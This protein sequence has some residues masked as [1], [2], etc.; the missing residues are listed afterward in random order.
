MHLFSRGDRVARP[1][2]RNIVPAPDI[3]TEELSARRRDCD[4]PPAE[5]HAG[6]VD[7]KPVRAMS[8]A[9]RCNYPPRQMGASRHKDIPLHR[10]V[11]LEPRGERRARHI[12]RGN[13]MQASNNKD[14]SG[15][16][17]RGVALI[18]ASQRQERNREQGQAL[19]CLRASSDV[20]SLPIGP[21]SYVSRGSDSE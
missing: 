3:I 17:R 14:R 4:V 21:L 2:D 20:G 18:R 16:N 11:M 1:R 7:G 10:N 5:R 9:T 19:H 12:C 13:S 15:R 6:Q 8:Q